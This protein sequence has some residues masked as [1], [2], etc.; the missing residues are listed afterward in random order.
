[1]RPVV[2]RSAERALGRAAQRV[3]PRLARTAGELVCPALVW[4]ESARR[5][6]RTREGSGTHQ[7]VTDECAAHV[8]FREC[9][10][11]ARPGMRRF[12]LACAAHGKCQ[13]CCSCSPR[14]S[15]AQ[16]DNCPCNSSSS[17]PVLSHNGPPRNGWASTCPEDTR[18]P[19]DRRGIASPNSGWS[20][21][22]WCQPGTA[23]RSAWHAGTA[24]NGGRMGTRGQNHH[25]SPSPQSEE[26]MRWCD[27]L[28]GV[29]SG[30]ECTC[31]VG[32][33]RRCTRSQR[34]CER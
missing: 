8:G 14:R 16:P 34:D 3:L 7:T 23:S 2:M 30:L 18:D 12:D 1:V 9:S 27:S 4:V 6:D 28:A 33:S 31:Q 19:S 24:G 26:D 32:S 20:S 15:S 10:H 25:R 22:T 17:D 29:H 13:R 21:W 5:C 11:L